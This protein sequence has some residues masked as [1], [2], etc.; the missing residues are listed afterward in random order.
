VVVDA[1]LSGV[2]LSRE[3][4]RPIER[5]GNP[6]MIVIDNGT[7]LTI[8]AIRRWRTEGSVEW[9]YIA[10]GKPMQN[11]FVESL[12]GPLGDGCLN[13]HLLSSLGQDRS[14]IEK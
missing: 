10:P 2:W 13:E 1:S 3:L 14:L 4:D 11:G 6:R 8:H 5:R 9:R 7:E 12:N